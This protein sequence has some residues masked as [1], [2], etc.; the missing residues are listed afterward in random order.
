MKKKK[1]FTED[2]AMDYFTMM[3]MSVNFLHSKGIIN[4]DLKPSHILFDKLPGWIN[5]L[6][7]GSFSI[8]KS[9]INQIKQ[10]LNVPI[11]DQTFPSYIAPEVI[12]NK[13]ATSKVDMWAL[14]IILY[15]LVSSLNHP[16]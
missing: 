10:N 3:L 5:I 7:I 13:P 12:L 6:K 4:R 8:S 14:G 11:E 2:E 9:N 1:T 15:Q 16:L